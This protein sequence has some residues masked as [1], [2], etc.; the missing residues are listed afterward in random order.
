MTRMLRSSLICMVLNLAACE[1]TDD[2]VDALEPPVFSVSIDDSKL[3]A[4][5]GG[6]ISTGRGGGGTHRPR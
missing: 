1:A 5:P 3:C 6:P 2:F 4:N